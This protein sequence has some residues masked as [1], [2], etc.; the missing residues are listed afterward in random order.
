V[1]RRTDRKTAVKATARRMAH[2][3]YRAFRYGV[4]F[5]ERGAQEFEE[6]IRQRTLRTVRNLIKTHNINMIEIGPALV[7]A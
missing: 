5:I 7:P 3:I 6:R 1:A 2:V 4:E